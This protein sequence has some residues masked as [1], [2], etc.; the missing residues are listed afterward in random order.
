MR[1]AGSVPDLT[2]SAALGGLRRGG[3]L[4][5][6]R[7][8]L[9]LSAVLLAFAAVWPA[10]SQWLHSVPG[11]G[12][13]APTVT[14]EIV[15]MIKHDPAAFT[16]GLVFCD[17]LLYESTGLVGFS[18]LRRV[19][20]RNG[21]TISNAP[22]GGDYFAEG[23]AVLGGELVQL[24]WKNGVAIRYE[25]PTLR[26]KTLPPYNYKGEGWGLTNDSARFIMS[27]GSDTLYFRDK[28][29]EIIRAVPVTLNGKP[30]IHLNE[31]E[32]VRGNV[33][34]NVWYKNFIV[35]ISMEN[36]TVK[37]VIDCSE[38]LRIES[39]SSVD[40][41]LNGIAYDEKKDEWYLTGKNWKNI[42]IVKIPKN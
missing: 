4:A 25:L 30:L 8:R 10:S 32:Y 6:G 28:K 42:F 1:T 39:P 34:A 29:F 17:T 24:T 16:Q 19:D 11:G 40:Q 37:R 2:P 38:L 18:S 41:V 22:L 26:R 36:G 13:V 20:P 23:I 9:L 12:A 27:N 3:Y 5:G 31:L 15:R 21:A 7:R 14:P 35:E 33:Y